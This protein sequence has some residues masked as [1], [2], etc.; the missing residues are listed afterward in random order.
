MA[1]TDSADRLIEQL[2]LAPH[3]EGGWYRETWRGD[4]CEDGRASGTAIL[5]L[6]KA[7]ESS[8]WHRVDA[9]E[10]W[11]WQ[12]GD[13]LDLG[14]AASD[15]GPVETIRLGSEVTAGQHLQGHVPKDAWQAA[16]P[17]DGTQGYCLVSC[18]VVPGFEFS[19]FELA[20]PDWEPGQ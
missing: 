15:G 13:P 20:G 10:M 14:I 17:A 1:A 8:H 12:A 2:K 3:P 9:H 4:A 19:G 11:F 16:E 18:V 6:L 5:F 7:G